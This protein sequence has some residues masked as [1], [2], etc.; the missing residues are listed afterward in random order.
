M[1]NTWPIILHNVKCSE[2]W[3]NISLKAVISVWF[4]SAGLY[5]ES[6]HYFICM[7]HYYYFL[8]IFYCATFRKD[9]RQIAIMG[10]EIIRLNKRNR[11]KANKGRR[12]VCKDF[13]K[14]LF[15][16]LLGIFFTWLLQITV[17]RFIFIKYVVWKGCKY[18]PHTMY[19]KCH[20]I[21]E[22]KG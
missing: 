12:I 19:V 6:G 7:K 9:V 13:I 14:V 15:F 10:S 2:I 21:A 20:C 17:F 16:L 4:L 3:E 1:H 11:I 18:C 8:C 22:V 5:A